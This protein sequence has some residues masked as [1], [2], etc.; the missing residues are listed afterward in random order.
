MQG[1]SQAQLVPSN[2]GRMC[3]F[4]N[5]D[6]IALGCITTKAINTNNVFIFT[7]ILIS[8]G[9]LKHGYIVRR[10]TH[11]CTKRISM[12]IHTLH[13]LS[14]RATGTQVQISQQPLQICNSALPI[15]TQTTT[16]LLE[17]TFH[18]SLHSRGNHTTT[19]F[20]VL[21]GFCKLLQAAV[22]KPVLHS[23]DLFCLRVVLLV[24]QPFAQYGRGCDLHNL[25]ILRTLFLQ[26][27][28]VC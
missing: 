22:S 24:P 20:E 25:Q 9:F 21:L 3:T 23:T 26:Q 19:P 12:I 5:E 16:C 2:F 1:W 27:L 15:Q 4:R 14:L 6:I 8:H 13:E 18:L 28:L 7:F 11:I 10:K 17:Q